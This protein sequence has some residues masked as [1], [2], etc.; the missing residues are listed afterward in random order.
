MRVL[1][2]RMKYHD[3]IQ[4]LQDERFLALT[5]LVC[6]TCYFEITQKHDKMS[7][8]TG[9][10]PHQGDI[11]KLLKKERPQKILQ[12]DLSDS[13]DAEKEAVESPGT[14]N[15]VS[16]SRA[17]SSQASQVGEDRLSDAGY[18]F[19]KSSKF[20][21]GEISGYDY[22]RKESSTRIA[23][24]LNQR[25][26]SASSF[27]L[28][29]L[30]KSDRRSELL[31]PLIPNSTAIT[32]ANTATTRTHPVRA[33]HESA[34]ALVKVEEDEAEVVSA[35]KNLASTNY[36]GGTSRVMSARPE[37]ALN[38]R[39]N[40]MSGDR[41]TRPKSH[42]KVLSLGGGLTQRLGLDVY[43]ASQTLLRNKL[44]EEESDLKSSMRWTNSQRGLEK[45]KGSLKSTSAAVIRHKLHPPSA[46]LT[47]RVGSSGAAKLRNPGNH[48]L[49]AHI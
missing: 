46:T 30:K 7:K 16:R 35:P 6:N 17:V 29:R 10:K 20:L 22:K 14:N 31:S 21:S 27:Q 41:T 13:E 38:R 45:M 28:N 12:G 18:V 3:F 39:S 2:P 42:E 23:S 49:I 11:L 48:P 5:V 19:E 34:K 4:C 15:L 32:R 25:L 44:L 8:E 9:F 36:T 26:N 33:V 47:R 1:F 40:L 24:G 37:F 43:Q